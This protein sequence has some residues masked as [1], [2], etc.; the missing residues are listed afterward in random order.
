MMQAEVISIGDELVSGQRLDTNTQWLSARLGE[1]GIATCRQTTVGDD[2]ANNVDAFRQA[3]G[4]AEWVIATGGLGPT[5]DDL[6]RQALAD[7]FAAPLELH[8][9]SLQHIQQ[10]FARRNR[11][12][13]ERNR[14]QAYLPRGSQVIP[15]PHGS[16][17]GIDLTTQTGSRTSRIFA[18][19]GVPAEMKQM[20]YESV[21]P[22][23]EQALGNSQGR[24]R[25][26]AV[27]VFGIGESDVEVRLPTLI[28]RRR[29]PTV[30]I[31]VSRAT[32]TLRLA[33]RAHTDQQFQELIGPTLDEIRLALGDL[34]F[35]SGDDE[36]EHVVLRQLSQQRLSLASLEIGAAS[37]LSDWMLQAAA[38]SANLYRGGL[39]FPSLSAAQQWFSGKPS[40]DSVWQDLALQARQRSQADLVIVVGCYPTLAEMSQPGARFDFTFAIADANQVN[41]HE[42]SMGGHPDVLGPRVA[43]T[44]MDL[45]R[46]RLAENC[47]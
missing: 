8:E 14:L 22:R 19:P 45:L 6:T 5:L 42:L 4:R 36:L 41:L 33:A 44:G 47:G 30:G 25:H 43:K 11:D 29:V 20:W 28:D 16:A 3:A 24:L 13:P 7:G 23:I 26:H 9:P 31:T 38:G 27:K 15:N 39:A 21:A 10:L 12:M 32:I 40:A 18:L 17:P 34:V 37:W 35:G 2:L 1:L 46:R